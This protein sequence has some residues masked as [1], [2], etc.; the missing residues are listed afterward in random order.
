MKSKQ[1]K[2]INIDVCKSCPNVFIPSRPE[3]T[4]G[5]REH[6]NDAYMTLMGSMESDGRR[7]LWISTLPKQCDRQLEHIIAQVIDA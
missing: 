5:C 2:Q 6:A 4:W 1:E 7:S 3:G